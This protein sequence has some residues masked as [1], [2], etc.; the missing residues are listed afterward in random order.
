MIELRAELLGNKEAS[1]TI[2][3]ESGT[4][5]KELI[6]SD[7]GRTKPSISEILG[8]KCKVKELDV[9]GVEYG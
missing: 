7:N 3:T 8:M 1:L 2:K 6:S 9:L 5:I 4:Y